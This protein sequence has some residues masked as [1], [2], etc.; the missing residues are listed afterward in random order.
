MRT[1]ALALVIAV[2]ASCEK[3]KAPPPPAPAPVEVKKEKI[4][5]VGKAEVEFFGSWSPGDVKAASYV[6]VAQAEACLPVPEKP[7]RFGESKLEKP[8]PLFA[9]FFIPQG[10]VGHAC[11][12]GMDE[13]GKIVSAASS[14]QN[15]MTF[16]GGG[17]VIFGKLDYALKAP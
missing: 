10:T 3:S 2:T 12:Y 16:K 15:P 6:F 14:T 17:E 8:G 13:A 1:L 4:D 9:E 11:V 5:A 7:T